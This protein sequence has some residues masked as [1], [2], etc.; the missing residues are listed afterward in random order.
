MHLDKVPSY[1]PKLTV[2]EIQLISRALLIIKVTRL[3]EGK[4]VIMAI[5]FACI[6]TLKNLQMCCLNCQK[7]LKSTA[8]T[9]ASV[10]RDVVLCAIGD[11]VDLSAT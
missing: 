4:R 1:L 8:A 7:I 6:K 10:R 3:K 5:S 9:C 2:V 11:H